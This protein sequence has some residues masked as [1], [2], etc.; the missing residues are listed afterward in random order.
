MN[1]VNRVTST[2]VLRPILIVSMGLLLQACGSGSGAGTSENPVTVVQNVSNYSGPAPATADV[3][4]FKLHLWD[5]LI[6]NNRC[7]SCHNTDQTPRFVRDDDINLA[8]SEANTVVNLA[9]P[10]ASRLVTNVRGGH[11][12]W[13][14]N[15][16]ACANIIESYIENWAGDAFGG[17]SK[18]VELEA[19][20][21]Q[22]RH[23]WDQRLAQIVI[24]TRRPFHR[25]RISPAKT[26]P[27]PTPRHGPKSTSKRRKIPASCCG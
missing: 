2:A 1:R 22:D 14:D 7:G 24:P 9:D 5:N 12:C 19:P 16:D 23:M 15:D 13:L 3:Q 17:A 8:Y 4:A 10:G 25:P 27:L 6:P 21:L 20:L 11:N 18:D 26:R